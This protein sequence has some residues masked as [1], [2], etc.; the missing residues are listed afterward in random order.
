LNGIKQAERIH[1]DIQSGG[2]ENPF[3]PPDTTLTVSFMFAIDWIAN[4]R[5]MS[6]RMAGS[7]QISKSDD[8]RRQ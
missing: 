1:G 5:E 8:S 6:D 2:A 7:L 4:R 3:A